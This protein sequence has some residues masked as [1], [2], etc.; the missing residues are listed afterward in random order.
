MVVVE[1]GT[2]VGFAN[3]EH[4]R[5][6]L[7]GTHLYLTTLCSCSFA[8]SQLLARTADTDDRGGLLTAVVNSGG[9]RRLH[10]AGTVPA[11]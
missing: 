11:F 10:S 8:Y 3:I 1:A 2:P 4:I 9:P 6:L 5:A 7:L